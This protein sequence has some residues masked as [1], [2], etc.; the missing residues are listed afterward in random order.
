MIY[1]LWWSVCMCVCVS[2]TFLLILPSPCQADD[3]YIMRKWSVL[4][5]SSLTGRCPLSLVRARGAFHYIFYYKPLHLHYTAYHNDE[6]DCQDDDDLLRSVNTYCLRAELC[7][8]GAKRG[9]ETPFEVFP[10]DDLPRPSRP[11]AGLGLVMTMMMMK[12]KY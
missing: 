5:I 3:I 9:V 7:A 11:K 8:E 1:I 2:V 10:P 6:E 12:Q 4:F